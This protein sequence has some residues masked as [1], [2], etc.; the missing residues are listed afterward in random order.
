MSI[1]NEI[2]VLFDRFSKNPENFDNNMRVD[3]NFVEADIMMKLGVDRIVEEM[4]SLSEFYKQIESLV[5]A[6]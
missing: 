6:V 5:E 3:W 1:R 2:V 4:G